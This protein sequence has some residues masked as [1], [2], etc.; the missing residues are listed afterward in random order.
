MIFTNLNTKE[1]NSIF[2]NSIEMIFDLSF[3][4]QSF[5]HLRV[6]LSPISKLCNSNFTNDGSNYQ[7]LIKKIKFCD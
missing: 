6:C 7:K 2:S 3:L 4:Y 1:L 5:H